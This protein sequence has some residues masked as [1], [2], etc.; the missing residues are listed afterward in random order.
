MLRPLIAALFLASPAAAEEVDI[1]LALLV[2]VS[3]SMA[4]FELE[5]QRHGY[6]AA[7]TSPEV[8]GAIQGGFLGRIAV[9]YIEWAGAGSH[10]VVVDW[11]VIAGPDDALRVADELIT[12]FSAGLR[13]TSISSAID[14]GARSVLDN[15]YQ[16]L[17]QVLDISGDGPNNM[18]GPVTE[19]RDRAV[20]QGLVINGL[21]L[22][23]QDR[24]NFARM[25]L[26]D[27][28]LYYRDCVIGG[29]G[30]FVI[31]VNDWEQFPDAVRRKLIL[32]IAALPRLPD[33]QKTQASG[34]TPE[35]YDC[36]IGEKLWRRYQGDGF[37]P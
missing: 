37:Q 35:G 15:D 32:E 17:R 27:L 19:A 31:P 8:L 1:E 18:G 9:S 3:R 22:M 13:R 6:A 36:M 26:S 23:T 28:D 34:L 14:F 16:G 10:N 21:P 30:A 24:D 2:D 4:P 20:A 7:L 5:I 33:L 11:T 12:S 25:S 29:P